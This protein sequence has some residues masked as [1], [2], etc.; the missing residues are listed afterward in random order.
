MKILKDKHKLSKAQKKDGKMKEEEIKEN[1]KKAMM[2]AVRIMAIQKEIEEMS[3]S[4]YEELGTLEAIKLMIF[5]DEYKRIN[6]TS[7][8]I[9]KK[10]C[11]SSSDRRQEKIVRMVLDY[12]S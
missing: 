4:I 3:E 7:K 12:I 1:I 6:E 11:P 8:K 2:K 9:T 10:P 5:N